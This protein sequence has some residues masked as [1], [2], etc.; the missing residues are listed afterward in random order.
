M[1]FSDF[2]CHIN[3][4]LAEIVIQTALGA[5]LYWFCELSNV[6]YMVLRFSD[7]FQTRQQIEGRKANLFTPKRSVYLIPE[8]V[9][10]C[11]ILTAIGTLI[12]KTVT[13]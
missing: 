4:T 6:L 11:S 2:K 9:L 10:S 7:K 3:T 8:Y 1:I 5:Y 12:C 13:A